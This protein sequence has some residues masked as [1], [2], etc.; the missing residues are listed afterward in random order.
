MN[1]QGAIQL[2]QPLTAD[3]MR[4]GLLVSAFADDELPNGALRYRTQK[5]IGYRS[6]GTPIYQVKGSSLQT[7]QETLVSAQV[8][9]TALNTSTTPTSII[10]AAARF[11]LPANFMAIGK[12][13]RVT[14][15]G[16]VSTFTSGTLTLDVRMGP[17]SNIIVFTGPAM[18]MIISLTNKTFIMDVMLTCRAIGSSTSANLMG[19]GQITSPAVGTS[20]TGAAANTLMLPDS[21]PAVGTGFDSTV[22]MVADL[23]ATWSVSNAANSIQVHQYALESLN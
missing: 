22:A 4:P 23:F 10:P 16:R 1:L 21:A 13:L 19:I 9:G 15:K 8:D 20:A 17:T 11:T 14:A 2:H 5:V 12:V 7:W 3:Q 6:D 18:V